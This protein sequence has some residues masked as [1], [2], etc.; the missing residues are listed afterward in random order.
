M[1]S[2][3]LKGFARL[4]AAITSILLLCICTDVLAQGTPLRYEA[5]AL[6][7][8]HVKLSVVNQSNSPVTALAVVGVRSLLGSNQVDRS[9]RFFDSLL[10]PFGPAELA[11][12]QSYTFVL[13]GPNPPLD[14]L[15][16]RTATLEAA[17]F[18]DGSAWGDPK[19]I[20]TLKQRREVARVSAQAALSVLIQAKTDGASPAQVLQRLNASQSAQLRE[21]H[22]TAERQMVE[23]TLSETK[24]LIEHSAQRQLNGAPDSSTLL[25]RA[26]AELTDDAVDR[27]TFRLQKFADAGNGSGSE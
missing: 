26:P 25:T 1:T 14:K 13:F 12:G 2:L 10:D 18:A 7:D 22:T 5:T 16:T 4:A 11:T 23:L 6:P 15:R 27:L 3:N 20:E 19:W 8:G 21:L 24:Q 9:V 17:L